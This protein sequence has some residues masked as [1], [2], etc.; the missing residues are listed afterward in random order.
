MSKEQTEDSL[1][2]QK[3]KVLPESKMLSEVLYSSSSSPFGLTK[4]IKLQDW[5]IISELSRSQ[6]EE[7]RQNM[8]PSY[9]PLTINLLSG[10]MEIECAQGKVSLGSEYNTG[11][12][13]GSYIGY[14]TA[15][16]G[17][18]ILRHDGAEGSCYSYHSMKTGEE[19]GVCTG[20]DLAHISPD[21]QYAMYVGHDD[22]TYTIPYVILYDLSE[23]KFDKILRVPFKNWT[24]VSEQKSF[25]D[26]EGAYYCTYMK[27]GSSSV[28]YLRIVLQKKAQ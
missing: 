9:T 6:Y 16:G 20:E 24:R 3:P 5:M 25:W 2:V 22:E 11:E 28:G 21:G 14:T 7:A 4:Q 15:L 27:K 10:E 19:I 13:G 1:E 18:H 8:H 12:E 23:G 17:M 26:K